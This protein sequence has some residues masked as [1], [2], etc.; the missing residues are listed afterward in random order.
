[1][2]MWMVPPHLMCPKHRTGEH[3]EIHKHR[4]NFVK[5]HSIS[6]RVSGIVQIEPEAME[7]RHDELAATL[8]N[9]R[10]PYTQP[11]LGHL[12]PEHRHARVDIEESL[13]ELRR[14]CPQC[15]EII[16]TLAGRN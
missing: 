4:H 12:P 1:M 7:R 16:D 2:R 15:R 11:S 14:R 8:K 6:G 13:A 3:G 9:H 5:Q 10:S